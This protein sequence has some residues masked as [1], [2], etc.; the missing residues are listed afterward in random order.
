MKT[1]GVFIV[2]ALVISQTSEAQ[3]RVGLMGGPLFSGAEQTRFY[4]AEAASSPKYA[5]GAMVE[6][7]LTKNLSLLAEPAYAEKGTYAQPMSTEGIVT[8][9]HFDLS[10]LE[11]PLL[12]KYSVGHDLRPHIVI[13]PAVGINLSSRLRGEIGI[14]ELGRLEVET[15]A[16]DVV[17]NLEYSL[18][19][20]GGL[21][22]Q[23]DEIVM[24]FLEARYSYGLSNI[25]RN[26]KFTASIF[27]ESAEV[28]LNTDP[29]YRNRGYR[30]MFG[31]SFPLRI[32]E[33]V[34]I[35][36]LSDGCVL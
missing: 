34:P 9:I 7:A 19:L 32:G 17:N 5:F 27:D 14:P 26:G 1:M 22:Y 21:S 13:G 23:I 15:S 33:K 4:N 11:F 31:V 36:Q 35:E 24:L 28:P 6:Y 2:A 12:L 18:E 8:R 30:I 16:D 20:G 29:V 25:T 3:V 10:Y